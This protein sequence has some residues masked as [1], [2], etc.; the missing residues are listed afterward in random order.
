MHR[1][2]SVLLT[3]LSLA[4]LCVAAHGQSLPRS[5]TISWHTGWSAKGGAVTVAENQMQGH[6]T[7]SGTT[8]NDKGSGPLHLG[9]ANCFYT[10]FIANGKGKGKGFCAFGDV[11]GDRIFT[12]WEGTDGAEGARGINTITGGTGKYAG[13]TGSGPYRCAPP[14]ANGELQCTQSLNYRLR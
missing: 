1:L 5:G 13:I 4:T 9:P 14:G 3:V 10:F 7:T 2:I 11:D 6:G 8:F 12:D